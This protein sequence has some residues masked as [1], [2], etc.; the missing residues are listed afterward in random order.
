[1]K[2]F[3]LLLVA[4]V[5]LLVPAVGSAQTYNSNFVIEDY[6][7]EITVHENNT[8]SVEDTMTVNWL[9][10]MHGLG[11]DVPTRADVTRRYN[12]EIY[13]DTYQVIISNVF[14]DGQYDT[15]KDGDILQIRMG[16]PDTYVTGE[17]TYHF[18]YMMDPGDD[19]RPEF[20]EFNFNLLE[21]LW[22]AP[23]E[24]FSFAIYMPK[25][26]DTANIGF[27]TG[28]YGT[29]GYNMDALKYQVDGTTI[30]GEVDQQIAPYEGVNIRIEL[31]D[32][33]YVGARDPHS[34]VFPWII[35]G[36]AVLAIVI[37]L[38]AT[39]GKKKQ[40]IQTV[41]FYPPEGM[42]SADV[43][44]IIDGVVE[45]KDAVSLLIYWADQGNLEIH[46][47]DKKDLR[48][49]KLKDL[50][51]TANDYERILF[52]KMF[53]GRDSVR[54]KDMQ[55]KFAS[56][57][58]AVKDR[59]KDKYQ[60]G[61]NLV[62]TK[63]STRRQS[64]TSAVA[65]LPAVLMFAFGNYLESY[66][67][68]A[69]IFSGAIAWI[70]GGMFTSMLC[71]NVNKWRSEKLSAKTGSMIVNVILFAAF[72]GV[73]A[74]F[75]M[76]SFGLWTVVPIAASVIMVILATQMRRRTDRGAQWSGRILGLKH[77]IETV[78]ADKLKML[79]E[80]DPKYFYSILP[81]AYVLGVTDKWAKQFE[82]IA[83]EP[84]SWYYGY[85]GSVFTTIWF[86]SMLSNSLYYTQQNMM[87]TKSSGG[88]GFGG[89][90]IGGGGGFSGGG[91]SG[92]GFGGGGGGGW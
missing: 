72:F 59:I 92:G 63:K 45:D 60:T 12:G 14:A 1:M 28:S 57:I 38:Y 22:P 5:V 6:H 88:S 73:V 58:A 31:P 67:W 44:Y 91:F 46:Q 26:F 18:G 7:R 15:E 50:P 53:A 84:P 43:G 89:G 11:V 39:A 24:H 35:G 66:E 2:K 54:I 51:D 87:A 41:E 70:F 52:D 56:T 10:P 23:V 69:A 90:G 9:E 3:L 13:K 68:F 8:Y 78:E 27:S 20:D 62:F 49:Q 71:T 79:V 25:D 19:G 48:F 61:Q 21:P 77:F 74:L 40:E 64:F 76:D 86:A 80:G 34:Q 16:D 82:S 36:L 81:Y 47:E 37:A 17:Q 29:S 75:S 85:N 42:N 65:V 83:V 4:L 30:T 33:Y 32:G 55:Y